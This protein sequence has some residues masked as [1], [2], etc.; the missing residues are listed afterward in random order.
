M[1]VPRRDTR[2]LPRHL[3]Q[4]ESSRSAPSRFGRRGPLPRAVA[5]SPGG[6]G[7]PGGVLGVAAGGTLRASLPGLPAGTSGPT[8]R[9]ECP[10]TVLPS[11]PPDDA[12]AA[13]VRLHGAPSSRPHPRA[14]HGSSTEWTTTPPFYRWRALKKKKK[15]QANVEKQKQRKPR[16]GHPHPSPASF[17]AHP[18][19]AP[20]GYLKANPS[21]RLCISR[22][23]SLCSR[24]HGLLRLRMWKK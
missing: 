20:P 6:G 15:L 22:H 11:G 18:P 19:H 17:C 13:G 9:H 14:P 3:G 23:S 16:T 12:G 21:P 8:S 24:R 5:A 7:C 1:C 2:W 4:R 10:F